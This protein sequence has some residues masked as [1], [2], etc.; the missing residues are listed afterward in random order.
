MATFNQDIIKTVTSNKK[1]QQ[2]L[3]LDKQCQIVMMS[4]PPGE[5]IGEETH[6]ADQTTFFVVGSGSA[7]LDG[8]K[9][10]VMPNHLLVI[11]KGT[12]H[13]ITNTGKEDMKLYTVYSPPAED[14]GVSHGTKEEAEAAEED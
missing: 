2:E 14:P 12:K 3:Y 7:E 1:W 6:K 10:N 11:P 9:T 13:N 5:D 8:K 4:I